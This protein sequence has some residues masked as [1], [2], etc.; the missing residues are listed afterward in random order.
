V[1]AADI[2]LR[3]LK[4]PSQDMGHVRYSVHQHI[5]LS[6]NIMSAGAATNKKINE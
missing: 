4:I 2:F 1:T 5:A 6:A 3:G